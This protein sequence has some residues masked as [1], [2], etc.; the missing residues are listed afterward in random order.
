L[1]YRGRL[2]VVRCLPM[3]LPLG[4]Q[5]F[6]SWPVDGGVHI[7]GQW[8]APSWVQ[9]G[10]AGFPRFGRSLGV[11]KHGRAPAQQQGGRTYHR[12]C[13]GLGPQAGKITGPDSV[14]WCC[15]ACNHGRWTHL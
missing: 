2:T 12:L 13:W 15:S 3:P 10:M 7:S 1:D 5:A 8:G 4:G 14:A 6:G 11:V 9:Q